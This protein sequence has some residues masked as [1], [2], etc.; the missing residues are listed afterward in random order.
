MIYLLVYFFNPEALS[1]YFL[2]CREENINTNATSLLAHGDTG[3]WFQVFER[4]EDRPWL[5]LI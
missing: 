3:P 1:F 4:L 2:D 5:K